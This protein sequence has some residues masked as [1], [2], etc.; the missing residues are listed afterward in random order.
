MPYLD[1]YRLFVDAAATIEDET[2]V[3]GKE[4][5]STLD[6]VLSQPGLEAAYTSKPSVQDGL[7]VL[8][9]K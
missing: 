2:S 5:R 8:L 9:G 4:W 1:V 6:Y 7:W 3:F